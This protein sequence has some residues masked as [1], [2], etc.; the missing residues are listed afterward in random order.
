MHRKG[1]T[2]IELLVVIAIIAI[3]A[4]ILFPVFAQARE[5][6]RQI[7][8][9][10]NARQLSTAHMMYSQDYDERFV[11]Y[12]NANQYNGLIA[13]G[14][15]SG[16][17]WWNAM[18][19]GL[20]QPY[21]KNWQ[22]LICPSKTPYFSYG[23]NG[24]HVIACQGCKGTMGMARYQSPASTAWAAETG[25]AYDWLKTHPT[26][27]GETDIS[28][29]GCTSET[30]SHGFFICPGAE[31]VRACGPY[32]TYALTARHSGGLNIL[33]LDGHAKWYKFEKAIAD[34]LD[35]NTDLFGH[36]AAGKKIFWSVNSG[37]WGNCQ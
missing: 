31:S 16:D 28:K 14:M 10:S 25:T 24:Y 32:I 8:C 17:A 37:D 26:P 11:W 5:K 20:L 27:A 2:L 33:F 1:F 6:A 22:I 15:S 30:M 19:F 23:V 21:M 29:R 35:P 34:G 9:L 18:W 3:L 7:S 36:Y 12:F 4:A 13:Q